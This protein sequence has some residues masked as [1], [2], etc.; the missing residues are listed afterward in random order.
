[1]SK[2]CIQDKLEM[3]TKYYCERCLWN[4]WFMNICFCFINVEIVVCLFLVFCLNVLRVILKY[5][6]TRHGNLLLMPYQDSKYFLLW[7]IY[8]NLSKNS[9]DKKN[10]IL[11]TLQYAIFKTTMRRKKCTSTDNLQQIPLKKQPNVRHTQSFKFSFQ[12]PFFRRHK[13][14][15]TFVTNQVTSKTYKSTKMNTHLDLEYKLT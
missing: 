2:V 11:I 10:K 5:L 8:L 14:G 9:I 12:Q 13:K 4:L 1:M 7:V 15:N 3:Q 6:Q